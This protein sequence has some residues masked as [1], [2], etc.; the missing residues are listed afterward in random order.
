MPWLLK[1]GSLDNAAII[2][3]YSLCLPFASSSDEL[4]A[5]LRQGKQVA[6]SGWFAS[7]AEAIKGG[8]KRNRCFARLPPAKES[9]FERL[10]QLIDSACEQAQLDKSSLAGDNV[11]VYLTGLG[12][13]VDAKAYKSFYDRN[14]I[15]DLKLTPSVTQLQVA[16]MS[17]DRLAHQLAQKY[18]LRA[19]P[20]NLNCASNSSLAAVHIGCQAIEKGGA[21]LIVVIGCAEIKTQDLWFLE[22]QS[23]LESE[24]AQPFGIHSKSVLFAEGLCVMLLESRRHRHARQLRAGIQLRSVYSQIGASRSYDA[25]YLAASLFR[26]MKTALRQADVALTDLCAIM[27]HGNGV[28]ASDKAEAQAL[29]LLLADAAIPVLAYKGQTGYTA[30]A[31]G[32]VDLIIAHHTLT[33]RELIPARAND[34]II[35]ELA[36]CLLTDGQVVKHHQSHLLKTGVSVD[37]AL[38]A[39]VLSDDA[40][41]ENRDE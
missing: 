18:S 38:I 34:A 15:D 21:D 19:L 29:T 10:S 7:D 30:T 36:P 12:P 14:D 23:M 33:Q 16:N 31:S 32:V 3:G 35:K 26:L 17:Q 20:P 1:E 5:N 27:P 13:R 24:V 11:R 22:S 2:A 39:V 41:R 9:V 4:I 28:E 40:Q 25:A 8:F 37:G 6:T